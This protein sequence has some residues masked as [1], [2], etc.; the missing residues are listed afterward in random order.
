M[1]PEE[2]TTVVLG[3]DKKLTSLQ[4]Q[5]ERLH[6]IAAALLYALPQATQE[7]VLQHLQQVV[8][9]TS[10]EA[11]EAQNSAAGFV[12]QLLSFSEKPGGNQLHIIPG[13]KGDA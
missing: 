7:Q 10:Q 9:G 4:K 6:F 3:M 13:G 11:F 5:N 2:L 8:P 12:K 1:N